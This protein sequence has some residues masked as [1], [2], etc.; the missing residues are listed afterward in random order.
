VITYVNPA[1][2]VAR[3]DGARGAGDTGM[4]AA[5][6]TILVGSVLAT[7]PTR[8]QEV[9]TPSGYAGADE[10]RIAQVG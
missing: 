1:I 8:R 2:A 4:L 5:F 10:Q 6:A 3:G 9:A 7:R